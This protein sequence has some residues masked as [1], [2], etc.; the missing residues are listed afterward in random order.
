M[1]TSRVIDLLEQAESGNR[2][3]DKKFA[4][5]LGWQ[6]YE[7]DQLHPDSLRIERI[8]VWVHPKTKQPS[9]IPRYTTNLD[10]MYDLASEIFE[11]RACAV[12]WEPG[13]ASAKVGASTD[14]SEAKTPMLALC[15]AV[16]RAM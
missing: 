7:Q 8:V 2:R 5:A 14:A 12:A 4:A 16:L 3:L 9:K 11:D 6:S 15:L 1:K 13:S 10:A